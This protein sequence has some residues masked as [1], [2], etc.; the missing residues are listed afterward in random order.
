M[1]GCYGFPSGSVRFILP[2]S[3]EGELLQKLCFN[4]S[5]EGKGGCYR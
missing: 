4:E 1:G 5:G 3:G 2:E